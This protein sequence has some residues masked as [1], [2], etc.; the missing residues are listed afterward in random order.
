MGLSFLLKKEGLENIQKLDTLRINKIAS[1]IAD[2][3]C[4]SFPELHLS[5]SDLFI[6]ISR[7]DMY[8]A[9]MQDN[10]SSAKYVYGNNAIYF[11]E[12]LNLDNMDILALHECIHYLQEVKDSRGKLLKLGLYDLSKEIGLA[13][14]EAAVQLMAIRTATLNGEICTNNEDIYNSVTYYGMSFISE[15]PEYYPLECALLAQMVF[16]TGEESLYFSTL[17]GVPMFEKNFTSVSD[18]DAFFEIALGFDKL[19]NIETDLAMLSQRLQTSD[20]TFEKSKILQ[21]QIEGKKK[22]I[23]STCIK[24]QNK[25]I[26][27][28]FKKKFMD[29][30]TFDDLRELENDLNDFQHLLIRPENYSFYN[31]FCEKISKDIGFKKDQIIKYGKVIDIPKDYS[32]FLPV[33]ITSKKFSKLREVISTLKEFIFGNN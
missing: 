15:S 25:I 8:T 12:N 33:P 18:S 32:S 4:K 14:N 21:F 24:I 17:Y 31:D 23:T 9:K 3:L 7:L 27:T 1:N 5:Q 11:N 29:C 30:I 22:V 10:F 19:L 13:L 2:K 16:F 26:E 6:Q 28:C 20:T